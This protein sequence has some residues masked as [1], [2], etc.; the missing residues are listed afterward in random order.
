MTRLFRRLRGWWPKGEVGTELWQN[1]V[2]S[3]LALVLVGWY[4]MASLRWGYPSPTYNISSNPLVLMWNRWDA[5]WYTGIALHGYWPEALAFFPLYPVLIAGVH[6]VTFLPVGFS[7]IVVS[8][9]ALVF[10]VVTF[11]RLVSE[12]YSAGIARRSVGIM[13]LFPTAFFLSAGY[14]ESLFLW[15]TT[16]AFLAARRGRFG[17]AGLLGMLATLTR[18]EGVFIAIPYLF[19]YY[20]RYG[21]EWRRQLL[22]LFLIPLGIGLFMGYQW[23]DFG[24]PLVFIHAEAFWG[25]HISWPGSGL[26]LAFGGIWQASPLQANAIVSMID[27]LAAVSSMVLWVYGLRKKLPLDWLLY[28][29]CLL[30]I[31]ISAPD[32]TGQSVLLSM[33]RLVLVLFPAFVTLGMLSEEDYWRRL[34]RWV[35]P[36]LQMAFFIVFA[37]WHWIA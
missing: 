29:G 17:W 23:Q 37:T 4:G 5:L 19:A 16:A 11:Y 12:Y 15:L 2:F 26:I 25:R 10:L 21:M 20:E 31:D 9:L 3:R 8:N 35:L 27:V 32:P 34:L 30:L 14:S 24:S 28:W 33:S 18:N 13:L 36:G 1:L 6:W 7:A 22:P